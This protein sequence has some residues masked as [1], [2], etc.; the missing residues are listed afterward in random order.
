MSFSLFEKLT[1]HRIR[2]MILASCISCVIGMEPEASRLDNAAKIAPFVGDWQ[3]QCGC[4]L[5]ISFGS[6]DVTQDSFCPE[7]G[8]DDQLDED[9]LKEMREMH[10]LVAAALTGK[11]VRVKDGKTAK[12]QLDALVS[13]Y[14][15]LDAA[16]KMIEGYLTVNGAKVL[17][18]FTV[19]KDGKISACG[20]LGTLEEN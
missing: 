16:L 17:F 11:L 6:F 8:A 12:K 18:T 2:M 1:L 13:R 10:A 9:D 14:G 15:S 19:T 7:C 3:Q 20:E 5:T 4:I